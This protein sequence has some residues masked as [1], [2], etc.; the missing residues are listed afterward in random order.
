[1]DF[2]SPSAP[3]VA[4]AGSLR[5]LHPDCRVVSPLL[6][7]GH[8][9]SRGWW[10]LGTIWTLCLAGILYECFFVGRFRL[11]EVAIYIV[12]GWLC[13]TA[14]QP[15][16]FHLGSI[17]FWLLV[18]GGVAYTLGAVL[19]AQKQIPYIHVIWHLFVMAGSLLMYLSIYNF[20]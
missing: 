3:R 6:S 7:G 10:L 5:C 14:M 2:T 9:R 20:V 4:G 11:L 17:G 19:Y 16:W 8:R 12:L 18:G 1:M 15:L 13:I